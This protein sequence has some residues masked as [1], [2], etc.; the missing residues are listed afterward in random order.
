[1]F[2]QVWHNAAPECPKAPNAFHHL[3]QSWIFSRGIAVLASRFFLFGPDLLVAD[4]HVQHASGFELGDVFGLGLT[5]NN[6]IA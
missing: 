3:V 1:M 4:G 5:E 2:F 6:Q